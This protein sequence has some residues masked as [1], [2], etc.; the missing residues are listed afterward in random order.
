M[1]EDRMLPADHR[2]ITRLTTSEVFTT[3]NGESYPTW[4]E[5]VREQTI[6]D[7]SYQYPDILET[8]MRV[9]LNSWDRLKEIVEADRT[10]LCLQ[11]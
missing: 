4:E 10:P 7:L 6:I 9:I 5:A 2:G 11:K 8:D 3:S 1:K